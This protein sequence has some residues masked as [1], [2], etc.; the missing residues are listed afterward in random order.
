MENDDSKLV[1]KYLSGDENA[2]KNLIS[3]YLKPIYNFTYRL[4]GNE[5]EASDLTQETFIKAWKN[6][7][8][9]R[10]DKEFSTW[11]FTIA[12]NSTIDWLRKKRPAVF[13]NLE[14]DDGKFE[15][16][17]VDTEVLQDE[18]FERKENEEIINEALDSIPLN[19]RVIIYLHVNEEMT[20]EEIAILLSQSANT[21]RSQYRRALISMKKYIESKM[22]QK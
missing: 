7:Q 8:K 4:S 16:Y 1:A 22:H 14:S 2:L 17:L 13:S 20:F 6:L 5:E 12:R 18:L 3:I 11:I 10:P 15:E 9:Y 19:H 21:A